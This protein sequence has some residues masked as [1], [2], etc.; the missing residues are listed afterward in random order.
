MKIL[1]TDRLKN[2]R[3]FFEIK[4]SNAN[5]IYILSMA[6]L[7]VFAILWASFFEADEILKT[8]GVIRPNEN[9]S[10]VNALSN[11]EL[12]V[13]NYKNNQIVS[14]GDLLWVTDTT[15]QSVRLENL[16][17]EL[18]QTE[19]DIASSRALIQSFKAGEN[20]VPGLYNEAWLTAEAYFS[21][22]ERQLKEMELVAEKIDQERDKPE[23]LLIPKTIRDLEAQYEQMNRAFVSWESGQ[24]SQAVSQLK[25]AEQQKRNLDSSIAELD[26]AINDATVYAPISG[27][28]VEVKKINLRDMVFSGDQL[29]RI[30]PFSEQYLKVEIVVEN[31]RIARIEEGQSIKIRF[32]GLP[33]A[34][35][36]QLMGVIS[37]VPADATGTGA[38]GAPYYILEAVI[39]N[40]Y[41]TSRRGDVVMIKPGMMAEIRIILSRK[42]VLQFILN[43]LHFLY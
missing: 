11:G 27:Q 15:S 28:I 12:L 34:E 18:Q 16:F 24:E 3:G 4:P 23:Y 29:V 31:S 7:V 37:M 38:D 35:F 1:D 21:E 41:L 2:S 9:V 8:N 33:V 13:K 32:K 36:G 30:I 40:P 39:D 19:E 26:K 43:K 25:M 20:T 5:G 14:A 42:T 6:A 10:E 17:S 22:R